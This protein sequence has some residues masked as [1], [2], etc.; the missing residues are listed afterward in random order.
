[1]SFQIRGK[2]K[3]IYTGEVGV[4]VFRSGGIEAEYE[5]GFE[6]SLQIVKNTLN[7]WELKV[8]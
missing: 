6:H 5:T 3:S 2:S 7:R 1:M 4:L 8:N